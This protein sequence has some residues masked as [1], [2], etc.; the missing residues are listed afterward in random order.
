MAG[1]DRPTGELRREVLATLLA[2]IVF[3]VAGGSAV[4]HDGGHGRLTFHDG[5]EGEA[6]ASPTT[7]HPP[8]VLFCDF[9]VRGHNM[10]DAEG[11]IVAAHGVADSLGTHTVGTW[12][13]TANEQ[14]GYDFEAGPFTLPATDVYRVWA[15]VDG[16]HA[17]R[18]HDVAYRECGGDSGSDEDEPLS[19]VR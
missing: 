14:G 7:A 3:G 11:T 10:T 9:W 13:G 18:S 15:A 4:A 8:V 5:G 19:G 12:N 2:A 16:D 1:I 6:Q 17:T